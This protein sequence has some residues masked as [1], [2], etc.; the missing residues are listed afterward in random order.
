MKDVLNVI[1]KFFNGLK[2]W[3]ANV[4]IRINSPTIIYNISKA[5][6]E[7]EAKYN[8]NI[9]KALK[10]RVKELNEESKVEKPFNKFLKSRSL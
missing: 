2:A 9:G 7:I 8:N 5:I 6:N 1:V 4:E 3:F 10:D